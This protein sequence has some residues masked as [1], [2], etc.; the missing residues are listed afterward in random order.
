MLVCV[1]GQLR[2]FLH[3]EYVQ[4][5]DVPRREIGG[6]KIPDVEDNGGRVVHSNAQE[7]DYILWGVA[8]VLDQGSQNVFA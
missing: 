3:V 6:R 2:R 7:L 8:A 4:L 5:T 1:A